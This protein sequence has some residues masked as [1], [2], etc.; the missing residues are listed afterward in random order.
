MTRK[1]IVFIAMVLMFLL[2][3]CS[4]GPGFTDTWFIVP[5]PDGQ[6][7]IFRDEVRYCE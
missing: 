7:T 5:C 6:T 4:D 2:T 1:H 3:A